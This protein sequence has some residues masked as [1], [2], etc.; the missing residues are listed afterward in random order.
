MSATKAGTVAGA[1]ISILLMTLV[2]LGY[3][4]G[5]VDNDQ[6]ERAV[7]EAYI[8]KHGKTYETVEY[9]RRLEI[10]TQTM[11]RVVDV[12]SQNLSYELEINEFSDM[13][14]EE[15]ADRYLGA[16][17]SQDECSATGSH[18][19][20]GDDAPPSK[21]WRDAGILTPVK[22]QGHCGSCWTFSTTGCLEAHHNKK[23]GEMVSLS[24]Q[25]LVDCA[26][27]FNNH[28]CNGGLPSHAFNYVKYNGG[29]N[30]EA[31]YPYEAKDGTCR[32]NPAKVGATVVGEVNITR[33][34]E[35]TELKDAVAFHGPVSIA[36][37]VVGDFRS[38]KSGVY[39][40]TACK[41]GPGDVNHAVLAVGYGTEDG[42]DYWIVKNSWG[43]EW[44]DKGYFKIARGENMCGVSTCA[45]YPLV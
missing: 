24:E 35:N 38:Y 41:S 22:N 6:A 10:F 17:A 40:S 26:Q 5:V 37:Q 19:L 42:E 45:S 44:G 16:V 3:F 39:R 20:T 8:A 43:P 11:R 30:T 31:A 14:D 34:A 33:G 18:P 1:T 15:F 12:N 28:G 9:E 29:I 23:T 36:F 7:F 13:T 32:F 27:A 2:G 21:D 4:D 25:N